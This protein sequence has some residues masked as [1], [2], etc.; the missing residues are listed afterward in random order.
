MMLRMLMMP[1]LMMQV[2]MMLMM[3]V[4]MMQ[5]SKLSNLLRWDGVVTRQS[6]TNCRLLPTLKHAEAANILCFVFCL[7]AMDVKH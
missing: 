5:L 3:Q 2:V 4:M 1:V 6:A 7:C